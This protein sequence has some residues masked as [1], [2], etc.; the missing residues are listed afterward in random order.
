[1]TPRI[2]LH[3][4]TAS[5]GELFDYSCSHD[6]TTLWFCRHNHTPASQQCHKSV[7]SV[8]KPTHSLCRT[9]HN[10][11]RSS[12]FVSTLAASRPAAIR[13]VNTAC[14]Q[15]LGPLKIVRPTRNRTPSDSRKLKNGSVI[16]RTPDNGVDF[17]PIL[18]PR[19][20]TPHLR[21]YTRLG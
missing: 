1:M 16:P 12:L 9:Y 13:S 8:A 5:L 20:S 18:L 11:F 17:V 21:L 2:L 10:L 6:P 19:P 4:R 15:S 3:V 14:H 7:I